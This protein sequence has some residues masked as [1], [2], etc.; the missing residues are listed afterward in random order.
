MIWS[1]CASDE[2]TIFSIRST[3]VWLSAAD[4]NSF[5]Q[6]KSE[7]TRF[8]DFIFSERFSSSTYSKIFCLCSGTSISQLVFRPQAT[9]VLASSYFFA[10][11]T[12]Q[13][14][15]SNSS[16]I[17]LS[18]RML[19]SLSESSLVA[20]PTSSTMLSDLLIAAEGASSAIESDSTKTVFTPFICCLVL[21]PTDEL[22][23]QMSSGISLSKF[24]LYISSSIIELLYV[25][26]KSLPGFFDCFMLVATG[27]CFFFGALE[28]LLAQI[29]IRLSGSYSVVY[30]PNLKKF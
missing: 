6:L 5:I 20:T 29:E 11:E 27:C 30:Q 15:D 7:P 16:R 21:L 4:S 10:L 1:F 28:C 2:V 8:Y 12:L 24:S 17:M 25:I 22:T 14:S 13:L 26:F 9:R 18:S 19:D 3:K 23:L